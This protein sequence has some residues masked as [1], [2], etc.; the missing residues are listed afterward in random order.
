MVKVLYVTSGSPFDIGGGSQ[1]NRCW[2]DAV[3]DIFGRENVDVFIEDT[4]KIP[5]NYSNVHYIKIPARNRGRQIVE[6]FFNYLT[7]FTRPLMS[8]MRENK[9]KYD[10]CIISGG[11]AAGKAVPYLV[12]NN[13]PT[14][15]IHHNYEV[16]YHRDNK[17]LECLYG[18]YLSAVKYVEKTAYKNADAN[19]FITKQDL[20]LFIKHYGVSEGTNVHIGCYDM[21][22]TE[23]ASL[24]N[25]EKKFNVAISGTL[26][27]YQTT[28]GI[29]DF[30]DN[31][32]NI[33]KEIIPNVK[34]LLTGRNPSVDVKNLQRRNPD[35]YTIIANP[36]KI[37]PL[38]QS[39]SIYVCPT[40][41]GGGLKLR[42]M[43]GLK[44]GLPVLVHEVSARGYDF[45][46][47]KPYFK[48]YKDKESFSSGLCQIL[49]YISCNPNSK[50]V[51]N[52][53]YYSFFGYENGLERMR[54]A[55]RI[56]GV[57]NECTN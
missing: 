28:V 36:D 4:A 11:L 32:L 30:N 22:E 19:L 44:C 43:D 5:N 45:Y 49:D 1:A 34:V 35:I 33:I 24:N 25:C 42:A 53:D 18:Y 21:K 38:V 41:I 9:N 10:I 46:F 50:Y 29:I 40:C 56:S 26:A 37:L 14:I 54:E 47:D 16:E 17:T 57:L 48:I 2:F 13:I 55:L 23:I 15:V 8:Y 12:K 6:Y 3:L 27:N 52:H 31:Y 7:R 39:A 20:A 51:I